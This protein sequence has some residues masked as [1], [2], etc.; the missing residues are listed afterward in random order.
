MVAITGQ[1]SQVVAVWW[2]VP[3]NVVAVGSQSGGLRAIGDPATGPL[4]LE[5]SGQP[6]PSAVRNDPETGAVH[7][8]R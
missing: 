7:I 8:G 6:L 5:A 3:A 1:W 4:S 2:G